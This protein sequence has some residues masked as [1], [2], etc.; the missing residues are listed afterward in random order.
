MWKRG[1]WKSDMF[2]EEQ[3]R[4]KKWRPWRRGMSDIVA[5]GRN[6][7]GRHGKQEYLHPIKCPFSFLWTL[8]G[9]AKTEEISIN[10]FPLQ[11]LNYWSWWLWI[12]WIH[13]SKAS[14]EKKVW[15]KL[16]NTLQLSR[17]QCFRIILTKN[18]D[19]TVQQITP[20]SHTCGS[21]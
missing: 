16:N 3:K 13:G 5:A 14:S 8:I 1:S 21:K 4:Q 12:I 15:I 20:D 2:V 6:Q 11:N 10:V 18:N 7:K 17:K 19:R 9:S